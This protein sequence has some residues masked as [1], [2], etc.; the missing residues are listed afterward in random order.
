MATS[1]LG[2]TPIPVP[3]AA[4]LLGSLIA[5]VTPAN[6]YMATHDVAMPGAPPIPYP[7]GH[8]GR[9]FAQMVLLAM[10]WKL[11]FQ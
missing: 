1:G 7:N 10:F 4:A 5:V 2:L 6:I 11:A 8:I 3:V 9:G